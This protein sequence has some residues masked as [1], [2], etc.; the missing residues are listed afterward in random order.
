MAFMMKITSSISKMQD[1]MYPQQ[2][3]DSMG[4]M[5]LGLLLMTLQNAW[6]KIL[7]TD[8][9]TINKDALKYPTDPQKRDRVMQADNLAY[10]IDNAKM[11]SETGLF[12]S[13]FDS[14]KQQVTQD[15]QN[16]KNFSQTQTVVTSISSSETN[17]I[18]GAS[19]Y[20]RS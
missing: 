17:L 13:I 3:A 16:E 11:D 14:A 12:R 4:T 7:Q 9:D 8:V 1:T 15:T 19:H 5:S 2:T 20:G 10:K 18:Q 6:T